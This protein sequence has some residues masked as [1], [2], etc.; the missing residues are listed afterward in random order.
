MVKKI[1][2]VFA[3]ASMMLATSC[4]NEEFDN[5]QNGKEST[6][7]FTAQLPEGLQ[8]KT[9]AYGDG[10][11]A[12]YLQYRA[13]LL[14]ENGNWTPTNVFGTANLTD[15]KATLPLK[16]V[17]GN[18][19]KVVF[20]AAAPASI[21][22]FDME[23]A[24][25]TANYDNQANNQENMD[26]FY[27]V[28]E[29]KVNGSESKTIKLKRPFAQLNIGTADWQAA[30]DAG[31]TVAKAAITVN[32]YTSL[33]FKTEAAGDAKDVTFELASLPTGETFPVSGYD[34]LTMNYLLMGDKETKDVTISYDNAENRTFKNVPLQRNY[35][36]N[37]Y[38]N[39]L[40]STEDIT[41]VINPGFE[42][43][44]YTLVF[45]EEAIKN[46]LTSGKGGD[47]LSIELS[48]GLT[49]NMEN[50]TN[51][52][53]QGATIDK[54][55]DVTFIGD[56][57]QTADVVSKAVSAEG[58]QLNYQRGSS[59]TFKNMTIQAGEGS[60]DGI[61]CDAL[62]FEN[63]IIKGKLTLY[64]KATFINCTFEND[65]DDQYS[66]WTWGGTEVKFEDCTFNT[67]G[68]AI[69]LYGHATAA[70]PTNL[71]VSNC[72]FNDSQNG[73]AGKAAIEVGNDYNATYTLTVTGC[74]VNGFA[75]GKN[76]GDK[77]WANK[78]KMDAA[79]LSVTIDGTKVQ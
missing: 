61:V 64:G 27:K 6:V 46:A 1:L 28:E 40:T 9:R 44:D 72:N 7:T 13:Y 25:V 59:F 33:D 76:T 30:K 67:N 22:T 71:T 2:S 19:Y 66:I 68:K 35:R 17:N 36:T 52:D 75:E 48:K 24:K 15:L 21:Y 14:G 41:V 55:R 37:I 45:S 62:T 34:Y 29:I 8:A 39:L 49:F 3:I 16:L 77:L 11:T 50:G 57:T 69:L 47:K 10:T 53:Q 65:M 56:G 12:T 60:F 23:N 4:S 63:C 26:A 31:R 42:T 54:R 38:G 32:T 20:W 5:I 58:G 51:N 18:T 74:T 43:P 70:K 79:H 78:N 73:S